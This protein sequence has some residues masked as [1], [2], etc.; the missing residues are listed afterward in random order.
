MASHTPSPNPLDSGI[1]ANCISATNKSAYCDSYNHSGSL[2]LQMP[3]PLTSQH[4]FILLIHTC[5]YVYVP[6][7]QQA[8]RL[9]ADSLERINNTALEGLEAVTSGL[10]P[11]LY[12]LNYVYTRV[13]TSTKA[14]HLVAHSSRL[15]N[16]IVST[17]QSLALSLT[18]SL[19]C[20]LRISVNY[21][22]LCPLSYLT[23][24]LFQGTHT[25]P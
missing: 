11:V 2:P 22:V 9:K 5:M 23:H 12:Q 19:K 7:W 25:Y 13:Y 16:R 1:T 21:S 18:S 10:R 24:Y 6:T 3:S 14:A 17:S 8:A 4:N 20:S 15:A